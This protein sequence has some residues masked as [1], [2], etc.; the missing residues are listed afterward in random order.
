MSISLDVADVCVWMR[1]NGLR[2]HIPLDSFFNLEMLVHKDW[3]IKYLG[4]DFHVASDIAIRA[5][6]NK[7]MLGT[8]SILKG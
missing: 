1:G 6:N 2:A 8:C 3:I 4:P 5:V 7:L